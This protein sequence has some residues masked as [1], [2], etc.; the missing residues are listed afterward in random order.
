MKRNNSSYTIIRALIVSFLHV[1][2]KKSDKALSPNWCLY[3]KSVKKCDYMLLRLCYCAILC[4]LP[5]L[6]LKNAD[7]YNN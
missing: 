3:C 5:K 2:M 4:V 6:K 7:N 1:L